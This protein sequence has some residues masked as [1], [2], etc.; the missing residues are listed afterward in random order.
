MRISIEFGDFS[1]E[2]QLVARYDDKFRAWSWRSIR[3]AA[4]SLERNIKIKMPVDTGRARASWGHSET[5]ADVDDGIWEENQAELEIVQGSKVE[6]IQALNEGSSRQAPVGFIDV[7]AIKA[8][9]E[10]DKILE[11]EAERLG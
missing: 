2:V 6:Y 3:R 7:E 4:L 9:Y 8:W 10:L 11:D 5:P 1:R